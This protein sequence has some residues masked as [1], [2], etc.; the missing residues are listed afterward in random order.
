MTG[1]VDVHFVQRSENLR[2][3]GTLREEVL[4][5]CNPTATPNTHIKTIATHLVAT[6]FTFL[7]SY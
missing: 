4:R 7:T 1:P 6:G 5:L 2:K 3:S